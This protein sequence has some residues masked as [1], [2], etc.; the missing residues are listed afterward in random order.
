MHAILAWCVRPR[1]LKARPLSVIFNTSFTT[2]LEKKS[3]SFTPHFYT[4]PETDSVLVLQVQ[5]ES[6]PC[7]QWPDVM[8]LL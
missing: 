8:E 7:E 5:M 6:S 4:Q 3:L 1:L 2:D